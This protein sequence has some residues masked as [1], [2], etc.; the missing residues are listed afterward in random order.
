MIQTI[1]LKTIEEF[2][3]L[4]PGDH[5]ACVFHRD[6]HDYPKQY[7]FKVFPIVKVRTDSKEV[8]LQTKNNIYFNYQMFV[9]GTSNLKSAMLIKQT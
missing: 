6:I 7:R 2:E 3:S 4:Q 5:V 1:E 9:E 8:I